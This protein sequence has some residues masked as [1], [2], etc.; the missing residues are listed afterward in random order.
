M[1]LPFV[2]S[3]REATVNKE[4]VNERQVTRTLC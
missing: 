4:Y 2:N 1:I 3:A